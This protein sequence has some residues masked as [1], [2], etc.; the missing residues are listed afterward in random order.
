MKL[1]GRITPRGWKQCCL[2]YDT[3][4]HS[5]EW[6]DENEV[7]LVAHPTA[8]ITDRFK[9]N[10]PTSKICGLLTITDHGFGEACQYSDEVSELKQERT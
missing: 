1:R 5:A 6:P 4:K 2:L 7:I 8:V 3:I 10:E 9:D